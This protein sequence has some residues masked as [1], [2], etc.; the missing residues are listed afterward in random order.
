[1]QGADSSHVRL[2]ADSRYQIQPTFPGIRRAAS[3]A[4]FHDAY[5]RLRPMAIIFGLGL[6][7]PEWKLMLRVQ[8]NSNDYD[9]LVVGAAAGKSLVFSTMCGGPTTVEIRHRAD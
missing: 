3:I 1:M 9:L 2:F 8:E 5:V 7:R 4:D 6:V